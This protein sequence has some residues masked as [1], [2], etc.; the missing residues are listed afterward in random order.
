LLWQ[1][2]AWRL[3][4][5]VVKVE[6]LA[7]GVGNG[8]VVSGAIATFNPQSI[9]RQGF[10]ELVFVVRAR[11]VGRMAVDITHWS[12]TTESGWGYSVPGLALNPDLPRRLEAG[13]VQDFYAPMR[14]TVAAF[15]AASSVGGRHNQIRGTVTLGTGQE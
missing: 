15:E 5:S 3:T 11:N 13:S 4:G 6:L 1:I 10:N 8:A 9:V 12:V 14:E 7:G 2:V